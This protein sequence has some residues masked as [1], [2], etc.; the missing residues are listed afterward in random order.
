MLN[1]NYKRFSLLFLI[2]ILVFLSCLPGNNTKSPKLIVMIT[3]DQFRAD[4]LVKYR[5]TFEGGFRR[6]L[7]E[8]LWYDKARV[9]HA[10]TLSWPGHTT[11]HTGA[12]PKT[13]GV[14]SNEM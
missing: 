5:D 13:H 3:P 11:I 8:G 4:Y 9:D 2:L 12:Y 7:D 14:V 10:P 1:F 6:L